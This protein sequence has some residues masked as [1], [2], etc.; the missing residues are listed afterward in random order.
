[1]L[2]Y[3]GK[4]I[5]S[6]AEKYS[7]WLHDA[8]S[9]TRRIQQRSQEFSVQTLHSGL[10][11][12]TVDEAEQL[13]VN[14]NHLA[15]TREV[16]LWSDG[17]PVVFA[18]STCA[19]QHIRGAWRAMKGLGNRPLGAL[20]FT[21]PQIFRQPLSFK[22]LRTGNPLYQK[23]ISAIKQPPSELWARRSLFV[24]EQAPLLVTEVFLP[25]ILEI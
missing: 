3:K 10:A 7:A 15:F 23:A 20:L 2:D 6:D 8:G 5:T 22:K 18:H 19:P 14:P 9:L 1:M 4:I 21:H 24:L 11:K 25:M 12:I 17:K 16:Y 13:K